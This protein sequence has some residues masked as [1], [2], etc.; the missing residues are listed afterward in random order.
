MD[1]VDVGADE[2]RA[3]DSHLKT[4][5]AKVRNLRCFC[6]EQLYVFLQSIQLVVLL[7]ECSDI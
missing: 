2:R 6:S 4:G 5:T 7:E 1:E 3:M